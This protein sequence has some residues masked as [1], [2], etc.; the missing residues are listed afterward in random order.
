MPIE[1]PLNSYSAIDIPFN[2]RYTCWFCGEPS[3]DCLNFPSNARSRQYVTHP[4][5]AIPACSECHSIRYPNHLT[6]IWALRA[7][8]KQALISKY[9]KHLGIGENWTEQELIDSDF[10]GAI[11]GGFGRSAWEMYNIAKQRVS[12]QG[13]PVCV[14]ELPIDCDDDTSYFEFN[15]THYSSLSACIDYFVEATGIDKELITEL[16]QILTPERFDYALQIAKLNR[17]PSHSQRTQIIDEIYQQEAEK[18][19]VETLEHQEQDSMEEV[20]VSGTIAPTFAIRWAIEN[21]ID[22]LSDL[23]EQEDAFFDDFEHL[24]GVTAFA[25]Y[26]GLQLY[27]KAREDSEWIANNDPNQHHWDR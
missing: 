8:I 5:L 9:T 17:R 13:W 20:S 3:S 24:G 6:S 27:L 16:V 23:C 4:L 11:L 25:S 15:G 26:N 10:S 12:F 2:L 14:D 7:H 21:G 19:E 18:H 22:N 1:P